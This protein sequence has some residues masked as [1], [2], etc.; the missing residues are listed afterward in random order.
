MIRV[1]F[2]TVLWFVCIQQRSRSKCGV[3]HIRVP[4]A[5]H[6]HI[7]LEVWE[8]PEYDTWVPSLGATMPCSLSG[9]I[10][11]VHSSGSFMASRLTLSIL[12]VKVSAFTCPLIRPILYVL[13]R[14]QDSWNYDRFEVGNSNFR[15]ITWQNLHFGVSKK[16]QEICRPNFL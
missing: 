16:I 14:R 15:G 5:V 11:Y 10:S 12:R 9:G 4:I 13:Y 7:V 6:I 8:Y 2:L 1:P 3:V